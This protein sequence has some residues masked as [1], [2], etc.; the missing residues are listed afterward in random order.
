MTPELQVIVDRIELVERQ[1]RVLRTT[2]IVAVVVAFV[3]LALP[4]LNRPPDHDRA[5]YSAVEANRFLLRGLDGKVAGGLET[6]EAGDIRLVLGSQG[7]AAAFLEVQRNG[8][9]HLSLRSEQGDVRAALVGGKVP[10]VSL[11]PGGSHSSAALSTL[12]D[13][14]GAL[15]INDAR[16]RVRYRIP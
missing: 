14:G 8:I 9:A 5:R 3:A 16:G 11:S 6:T 7:T 12:P 4:F 15:L 10:S 13:G 1:N 2:A